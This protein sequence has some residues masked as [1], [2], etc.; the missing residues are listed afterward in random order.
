MQVV[1]GAEH[2]EDALLS[3]DLTI[4]QAGQATRRGDGATAGNRGVRRSPVL[5]VGNH[6]LLGLDCIAI[7]DQVCN[8]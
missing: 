7:L 5:L 1:L 4:A 8:P 6:T 2:L 3:Q